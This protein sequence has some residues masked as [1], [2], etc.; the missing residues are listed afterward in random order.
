MTPDAPANTDAVTDTEALPAAL[1][2]GLR[3]LAK[4]VVI[5]TCR[6]G[7]ARYAMAATAVSEVSL[8]PPSMLVCVNK[9]ASLFPVLSEGADFCINILSATQAD[10]ANQCASKKGEERFAVGEWSESSLGV[11]ILKGAQASFV[12]RH[13]SKMEYG[14]HGVFI[15]QVTEVFNRAPANPLVYMDRRYSRVAD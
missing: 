9:S 11:P 15:G 7:E 8:D 14:T 6:G 13:V 5:V 2:E 1:R 12:C 10:V 4:A 3:S